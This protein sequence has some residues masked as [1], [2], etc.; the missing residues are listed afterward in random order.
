MFCWI[1]IYGKDLAKAKHEIKKCK[2]SWDL[3]SVIKKKK[4]EASNYPIELIK[5]IYNV[6]IDFI[7]VEQQYYIW[8]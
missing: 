2:M 8:L 3:Y 6:I 4:L 1:E 7:P 5:I